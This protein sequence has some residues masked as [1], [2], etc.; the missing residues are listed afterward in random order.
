VLTAV[1]QWGW[2]ISQVGID[3]PDT[4][5]PI[6]S[7]VPLMMFA[8][9]FGLSMDYEVFLVSHVQMHHH[10]GEPAREAV[11]NGLG[12][13]ARIT[14]AAA[15]IMASVFASFILNGDPV[16]KQFGVGLATAVLLAGILVVTLAPAAIV[17]FGSAAWWLPGWLDKVLP[18]IS[19]EGETQP[20]SE[21]GPHD[22]PTG[23][24]DGG[25]P[26]APKR[27]PQR[28]PDAARV[29]GDRAAS[30]D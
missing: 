15:L 28:L 3:T 8:V 20:T 1:F 9:L 25:T 12:S 5:V 10:R 4:S 11:A 23:G 17:L 2:G 7:Y 6:A 29:P 24:P 27:A 13:S 26:V 22:R 30:R 14:S 18:H 19:V 16:I 21:P